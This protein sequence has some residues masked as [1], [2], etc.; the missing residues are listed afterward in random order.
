MKIRRNVRIRITRPG[1]QDPIHD[2]EYMLDRSRR[3]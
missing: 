3:R 1:L 2:T